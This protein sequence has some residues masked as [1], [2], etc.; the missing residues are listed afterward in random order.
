MSSCHSQYQAKI[1]IVDDEPMNLTI[2]EDILTSEGYANIVCEENPINAIEAYQ[3]QHFD[4][5]LLDL[6]M[7]NKTGFEVMDIFKGLNLEVPP[8]V[9]VLT[10]L[11]DSLTKLKALR[12]GASDFVTKPFDYEEVVS[13]VNNLVMMR[14]SMKQLRD[15]NEDI[16]SSLRSEMETVFESLALSPET[17]AKLLGVLS[18]VATKS[19]SE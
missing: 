10:A 12:G 1:L 18:S 4:L 6:N 16:L 13:R 17:E 8:P 7:P 5:V 3:Q 9:L 19:V 11:N 2:L 14:M 15:N